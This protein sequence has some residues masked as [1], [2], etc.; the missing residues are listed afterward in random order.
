LEDV[1]SEFI[2]IGGGT[3]ENIII[4]NTYIIELTEQIEVYTLPALSTIAKKNTAYKLSNVTGIAVF[5]T[6]T[7]SDI[8][9]NYESDD[10]IPLEDGDVIDLYL[11][12]NYYKIN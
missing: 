6:T 2:S 4:K 12:D 1:S 8:V 10:L 9:Y 5:L 3:T 7:G 11:T